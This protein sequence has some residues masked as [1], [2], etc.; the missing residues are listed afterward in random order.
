MFGDQLMQSIHKSKVAPTRTCSRVSPR[1]EMLTH[2]T[3]GMVLR[4][5]CLVFL[6]VKLLTPCLEATDAPVVQANGNVQKTK[7]FGGRPMVTAP[8]VGFVQ[9]AAE[10]PQLKL[11]G[12]HRRGRTTRVLLTREIRGQGIE[13]LSISTGESAAGIE[14]LDADAVAGSTRLR[15]NGVE[16]IL[17][18]S[19]Q[20]AAETA[21]A[22]LV[23]EHAQAG[24]EYQR[25]E[26]ERLAEEAQTSPSIPTAANP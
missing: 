21:K 7:A 2:G 24:E 26:Q 25:R 18:F 6:W 23:D 10:V 9:P 4:V 15:V 1:L 11:T 14:I 5:V 19:G 12:L 8:L 3:Q 20:I 13:Y 17:S 16:L 22:R